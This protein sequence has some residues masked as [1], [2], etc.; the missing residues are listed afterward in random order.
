MTRS[1]DAF[2][3]SDLQ[4]AWPEH[5][6]PTRV[7]MRTVSAEPPGECLTSETADMTYLE[8]KRYRGGHHGCTIREKPLCNMKQSLA[9]QLL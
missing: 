6:W 5:Q 7:A 4:A 2:L 8:R 3:E 9:Y 1:R